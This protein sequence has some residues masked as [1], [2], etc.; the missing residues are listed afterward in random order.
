MSAGHLAMAHTLAWVT[1]QLITLIIITIFNITPIFKDTPARLSIVIRAGREL[2]LPSWYCSFF[3]S[4]LSASGRAKHSY[5][6]LDCTACS[7]HG[8]RVQS[9][10]SHDLLFT[11]AFG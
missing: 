4:S 9:L 7:G 5:D 6:I 1:T 2:W 10:L 8:R 3:W 11:Y